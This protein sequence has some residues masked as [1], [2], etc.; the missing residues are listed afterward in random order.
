MSFL[1]WHFRRRE[2]PYAGADIPR[3]ARLAGVLWVLGAVL[4]AG[5]LPVAPPDAAIG[6]A[7]WTV[8]GVIIVGS[9]LAAVR[10]FKWTDRVGV[11]EGLATCFA[12]LVLIAVLEWLAGGRTSP[13]HQLLMLSVLY[14]ASAHPPRRFLAHFGA[15][16]LAVAA[17]FVYGPFTANQV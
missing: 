3:A 6:P 8:A 9:L 4:V 14:T 15:Y 1:R 11:K 5:L 13:Y 10:A 12:A 16:V 17:P 7:G 2:D